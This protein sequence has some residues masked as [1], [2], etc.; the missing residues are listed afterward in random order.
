MSNNQGLTSLSRQNIKK[1]ITK[2]IYA[3]QKK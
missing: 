1:I 3:K 2:R